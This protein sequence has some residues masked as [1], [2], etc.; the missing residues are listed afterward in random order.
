LIYVVRFAWRYLIRE[1]D[2]QELMATL[3]RTKAEI[4]GGDSSENS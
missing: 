4:F 3:D 1:H 2:R